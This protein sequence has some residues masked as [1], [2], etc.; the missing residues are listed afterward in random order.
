MKNISKEEFETKQTVYD[1]LQELI[2]QKDNKY[3]LKLERS[4]SILV[5]YITRT[6]SASTTGESVF[7]Y[8]NNIIIQPVCLTCEIVP[9]KFISY[10]KGYY[11][12]C[13]KQC[14]H[15]ET[16]KE[17]RK[18]TNLKRYGATSVLRSSVGQEKTKQTMLIKYG[19]THFSKTSEYRK[20]FTATMKER[21]GVEYSGQSTELTQK[22]RNSPKNETNHG[23]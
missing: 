16:T 14:G 6:Y 17:N 5:E 3:I 20:K 11:Q 23:R 12:Y 1:F 15:N 19:V 4:N 10:T 8:L 9:V 21:H 13:C 7:K 22:R 2:E 18:Q